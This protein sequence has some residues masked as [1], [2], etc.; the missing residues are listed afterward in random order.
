MNL[1]TDVP[2]WLAGLVAIALLAAAAEDVLRLR[3]SNI[4]IVVVLGAA[5]AAMALEG[6]RGPLWQNALI[7]AAI[8]AVGTAAFARDLLGGGDVKLLAA[9]GLW[10]NLSAAVWLLASVF[11]AGGLVALVYIFVRR[12]R[13]VKRTPTGNRVPYGVAIA[14]GALFVLGT[15]YSGGGSE[16]NFRPL[17]P[18]KGV[19][20]PHR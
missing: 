19:H 2:A 14:A 16:R 6:F 8:L 10:V 9:T 3:I 7:F 12:V 17:P 15:Q 5:I 11:L 20:I 4:T 1:I 18:I 13:G